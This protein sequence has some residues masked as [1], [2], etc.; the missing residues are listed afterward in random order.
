VLHLLNSDEVPTKLSRAGGRADA[1]AKDP[2]PDADKVDELFLWAVGH[3]PNDKK[4]QLALDHVSGHPRDKK[5]AYENI[6]WALI[7]TKEFLFN[8]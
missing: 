8:E 5:T 2:R 4:R 7:N 1:L 3:K 6:L